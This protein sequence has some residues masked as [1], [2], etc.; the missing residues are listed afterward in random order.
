LYSTQQGIQESFVFK[1]SDFTL[2]LVWLPNHV[3]VRS[4]FFVDGAVRAV[5][6]G[7]RGVIRLRL[8]RRL[9]SRRRL[10]ISHGSFVR[11]PQDFRN[12]DGF[13]HGPIIGNI[14]SEL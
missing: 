7:R 12:L 2:T 4:S 9:L 13:Y 11:N 5:K 8:S 1:S 3:D 14:A 6:R 10:P